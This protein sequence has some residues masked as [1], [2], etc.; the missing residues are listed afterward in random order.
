MAGRASAGI[1]AGLRAVARAVLEL[2]S[3]PRCAACG[4]PISSEPF[5]AVCAEAIE[6]VPPGCGRCGL[7]GP[8]DP[9]GACR[10][11]P[12]AFDAVQAGGLFGGPLADAVHAL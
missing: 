7:P 3:P 4:E 9:C 8:E 5:C 12:P 10:S 2:V 1:A 11:A 6:A